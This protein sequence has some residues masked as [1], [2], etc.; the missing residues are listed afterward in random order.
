MIGAHGLDCLHFHSFPSMILQ[1][2]LKVTE[3]ELELI[4]DPNI[5]LM[6]E[7][8]IHSRLSYVAQR[9]TIANFP[10]MHDYRPDLLT[11]HLL[12][13][14][15]NSLYTTCQTYLLPVGGLHFFSY[16]ELATFNV[17]SMPVD[18][19]TGYFVECDLHYPIK[20][21]AL[22]DAYPLA[23]EHMYNKEMLSDML[24]LMQDV[25]VLAHHLC[26]NL[27]SN[28]RDK[29]RYVTHDHCVPFYLA[30][31]LR[32]E[33]IHCIVAFSQRAYMLPFCNDGWKNAQYDFESDCQHVLWQGGG[34][35]TQARQR[36][37][38]R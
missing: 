14:D 15:C 7:S 16:E 1:L 9:H 22:H 38:D 18:S 13:L 20:L 17:A 10:A 8:G 34:K 28:L 19:P 12:Y 30:H 25:T 32:L 4:T 29:T 3:V 31:G 26:T 11:S 5:Y 27:V 37:S 35:C 36:L 24:R 6:I 23:T 21:H 2:A 33:K